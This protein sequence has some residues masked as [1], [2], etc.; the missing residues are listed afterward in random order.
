MFT[1]ADVLRHKNERILT[2]QLS[3]IRSTDPASLYGDQ[4]DHYQDV[5]G[6]DQWQHDHEAGIVLTIAG[7]IDPAS[8]DLDVWTA[9][10]DPIASYTGSS[11]LAVLQIV[12]GR[13]DQWIGIGLVVNE[14]EAEAVDLEWNGIGI[15]SD[16]W[17]EATAEADQLRTY[18]ER[19]YQERIKRE[20]RIR[21]SNKR[22][23]INV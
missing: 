1:I 6:R 9:N 21:N 5:N 15:P 11:C 7:R 17:N 8:F 10:G 22:T 19:R 2:Q 3:Q 18:Q 12:A 14:A 23:V 4:W 16:Q 20:D 13:I